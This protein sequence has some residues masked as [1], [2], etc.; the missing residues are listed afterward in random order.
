MKKLFITLALCLCLPFTAHALM[1]IHLAWD[2]NTETDLA[3]YRVYTTDTSGVY[4][5]GDGNQMCT[6]AAGTE[7]CEV[8]GIPDGT[9]YF[10]LT[11]YDVAGNESGPSNEVVVNV[12]DDVQAPGEP[13]N[14]RFTEVH[15]Y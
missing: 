12:G 15:V 8:T 1:D 14:F 2:A 9:H 5:F 7:I 13:G 11:A 10:V 4:T 6:I 3:G